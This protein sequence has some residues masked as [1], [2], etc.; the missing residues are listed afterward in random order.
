MSR[1]DIF[2]LSCAALIAIIGGLNFGAIWIAGV[3]IGCA[4]AAALVWFANKFL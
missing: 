3:L 1:K 2:L 4:S